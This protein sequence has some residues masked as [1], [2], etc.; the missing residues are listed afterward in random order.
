[1]ITNQMR[2]FFFWRSDDA[3]M[4][5]FLEISRLECFDCDKSDHSTVHCSS[6]NVMCDK[7]LVHCDVNSR[8]CW[9]CVEDEDIDI[10][11]SQ[12]QVWK[13]EITRQVKDWVKATATHVGTAAID[14]KVRSSIQKMQVQS[15]LVCTVS[16]A[17]DS[18]DINDKEVL[19]ENCDEIDMLTA[20]TEDSHRHE[21]SLKALDKNKDI[22][23]EHIE[24]EKQYTASK[25]LHHED[26]VDML[27]AVK[28]Q[29]N[30]EAL[31]SDIILKTDSDALSSQSVINDIESLSML[32]DLSMSD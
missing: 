6:I 17:Y 21:R 29:D 15:H 30:Q 24:K 3:S 8:L 12:D 31:K 32:R 14:V 26:Y 20:L 28:I 1:M 22:V 16:K 7:K 9:E 5:A 25:V 19:S 4:P 23:Q 2:V 27:K 10:H 13:E 18:D 11:L